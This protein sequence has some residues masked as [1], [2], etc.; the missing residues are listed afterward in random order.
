MNLSKTAYWT[1][2]GCD[3]A[4]KQRIADR[5]EIKLNRLYYWIKMRS[6]NLTK[7]GY[8]KI[9]S[10][11]LGLTMSELLESADLQF[12]TQAA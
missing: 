10:E 12:T 5:M 6:D 8:L 11:E 7:A 9:L 3:G 1:L 2:R 4:T